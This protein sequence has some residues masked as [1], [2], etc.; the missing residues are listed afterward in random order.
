MTSKTKNILGWVLSGLAALLLA[1]SATDKI[2]GSS[3]A[4]QIASLISLTGGTYRVLGIIELLSV[5]LFLYPRTGI[6][7]T[8]LLSSYLGGAIATHLQHQQDVLFPAAFEAV[9]WIAAV[10]R[11][12]ELTRRI[13][14]I[15][16]PGTFL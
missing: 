15:G 12:P 3:H 2:S 4:L 14:S 6:L 8:L 5:I 9:I 13:K 16:T 11:F 7:G 10:I 1:A